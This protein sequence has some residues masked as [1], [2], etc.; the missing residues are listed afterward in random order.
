[1]NEPKGHHISR[2]RSRE[3]ADRLVMEYEQSGLTRQA[4]CR[5]R[6]LSTAILDNYRKRRTFGP[7]QAQD[8]AL[9]TTSASTVFTFV[10]FELVERSSLNRQTADNGASLYVELARGRRI[11]VTAGFD[12]AVHRAWFSMGEQK[13][14][15]FHQHAER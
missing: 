4:F 6:G 2:R 5:Q 9:A 8:A 13:L 11:G 15:E 7:S 1:M 3:E 10:P 12:A 14:R